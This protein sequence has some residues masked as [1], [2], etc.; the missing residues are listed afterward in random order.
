MP[1]YVC[2]SSQVAHQPRLELTRS[3]SYM[4]VGY[5]SL[6]Q[7]GG[8]LAARQIMKEVVE[9]RFPWH[10]PGP[11]AKAKLNLC[12]QAHTQGNI[13]R[14][15]A[16]SDNRNQMGSWLLWE[17]MCVNHR[18]SSLSSLLLLFF[19]FLHITYYCIGKCVYDQRTVPSLACM[20][21]RLQ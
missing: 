5:Q 19:F 17:G 1:L 4:Q 8:T 3:Q 16:K 18:L 14:T 7:G 6:W 9:L 21:V 20:P 15:P 12:N 10:L 11:G 13:A 2:S